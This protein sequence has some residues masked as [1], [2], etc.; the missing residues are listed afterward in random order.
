MKQQWFRDV[1][2]ENKRGGKWGK[3]GVGRTRAC[4]PSF[5]FRTSFEERFCRGK[6]A[7]WGASGT[8]KKRSD[9]HVTLPPVNPGK[10][11]AKQLIQRQPTPA[12][13]LLSM[14]HGTL[15]QKFLQEGPR[16]LLDHCS[17]ICLQR[18]Q[19]SPGSRGTRNP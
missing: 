4:S 16:S 8:Q 11:Q 9:N 3:G 12:Q 10:A 5:Y 14:G 18:S 19:W 2:T 17:D 1:S 13:P 6:P 7:G 15:S